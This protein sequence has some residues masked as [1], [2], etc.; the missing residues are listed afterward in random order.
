VR[1]G[2]DRLGFGSLVA[3]TTPENVASQRVM[4]KA[5]LAY[6]R[7]IVHAGVPHVLFRIGGAS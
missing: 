4:R 3:I 2:F 1:I 6:E 7:D 5:G